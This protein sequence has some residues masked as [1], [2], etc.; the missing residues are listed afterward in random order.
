MD[1]SK[2]YVC[3]G[4]TP[5]QFT[6]EHNHFISKLSSSLINKFTL[7]DPESCPRQSNTQ[8]K[9]CP[10]CTYPFNMGEI[11]AYALGVQFGVGR[12]FMWWKNVSRTLFSSWFCLSQAFWVTLATLL[13]CYMT[14]LPSCK[15]MRIIICLK[16]PVLVGLWGKICRQVSK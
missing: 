15:I 5:V 12:I 10:S 2:L 14:Q 7:W 3:F 16:W 1:F 8:Q 6:Y 13:Y 4:H 11:F 9:S